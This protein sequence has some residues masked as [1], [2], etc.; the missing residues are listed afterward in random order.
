MTHDVWSLFSISTSFFPFGI[1]ESEWSHHECISFVREAKAIG[2]PSFKTEWWKID[3]IILD[4]LYFLHFFVES[5]TSIII[6]TLNIL[7]F[8]I[9]R[10]TKTNRRSQTNS[11]WKSWNEYILW[12]D[13][14]RTSCNRITTNYWFVTDRKRLTAETLEKQS[15]HFRKIQSKMIFLDILFLSFLW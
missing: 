5:K 4:R 1:Y 3:T 2:L 13:M 10:E 7:M 6:Y 11:T 15:R 14:F 12:N 9:T 8:K